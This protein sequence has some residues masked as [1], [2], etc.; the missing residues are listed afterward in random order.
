V[1]LPDLDQQKLLQCSSTAGRL[2]DALYHLRE[3]SG[4]LAALAALKATGSGELLGGE[5]GSA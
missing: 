3:M 1:L 2:E 4:R 5:P